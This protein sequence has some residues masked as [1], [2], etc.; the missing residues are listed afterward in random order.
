M[1]QPIYYFWIYL[2]LIFLLLFGSNMKEKQGIFQDKNNDFFGSYKRKNSCF[3]CL[4][5]MY[6]D[7]IFSKV[8]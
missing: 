4:L 5:L 1:V 6:V 7:F 8:S 3:F 2:I